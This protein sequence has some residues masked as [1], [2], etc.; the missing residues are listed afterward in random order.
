MYRARNQELEDI[1]EN[2]AREV[3]KLMQTIASPTAQSPLGGSLSQSSIEI[4][5]KKSIF[6]AMTQSQEESEDSAGVSGNPR[7]AE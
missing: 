5:L 2:L 6:Q 3:Q 4:D 1:N 7:F